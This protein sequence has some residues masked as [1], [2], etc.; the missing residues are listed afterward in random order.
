MPRVPVPR[1]NRKKFCILCLPE[2][3]FILFQISRIDKSQ[4]II[5]FKIVIINSLKAL[6]ST[7]VVVEV[8]VTILICA[9]EMTSVVLF[10]EDDF[11]VKI[12]ES[13]FFA[14]ELFSP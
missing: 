7:I 2:Y 1:K 8:E 14:V 11:V 10:K 12:V 6:K 9:V 5:F 4:E 3:L 13:T